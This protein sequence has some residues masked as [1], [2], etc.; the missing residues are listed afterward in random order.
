MHVGFT[1]LSPRGHVKKIIKRSGAAVGGK[2]RPV[3]PRVKKQGD[4][5]QFL[6][7]SEGLLVN[8][9]LERCFEPSRRHGASDPLVSTSAP[10][11]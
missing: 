7:C 9:L 11:F 1:T 6:G 4:S 2:E 8:T 10:R 3:D 5:H